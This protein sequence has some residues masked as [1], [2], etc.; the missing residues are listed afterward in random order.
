M[1]ESEF[2][3]Y[4]IAF[5]FC[6]S[7][8]SKATIMSTCYGSPNGMDSP[9]Y[10]LCRSGDIKQLEQLLTLDPELTGIEDPI[11]KWTPIHWAANYGQVKIFFTARTRNHRVVEPPVSFV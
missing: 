9:V 5:L 8:P 10:C 2:L 11:Q 1:K 3:F 6:K 7:A 4:K